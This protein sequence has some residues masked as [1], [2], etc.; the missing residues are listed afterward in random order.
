[1]FGYSDVYTPPCLPNWQALYINFL[2]PA[3]TGQLT[4]MD[5][6]EDAMH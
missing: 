1:M 2:S 3:K 4:T 6:H 5:I